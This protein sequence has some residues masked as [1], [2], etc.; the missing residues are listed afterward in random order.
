MFMNNVVGA[1]GRYTSPIALAQCMR[2]ETG[3]PSRGD[4][5]VTKDYSLASSK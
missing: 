2:L 4:A 3:E 1:L 5:S